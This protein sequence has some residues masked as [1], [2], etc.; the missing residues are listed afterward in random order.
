VP[1]TKRV[2]AVALAAFAF[3]A[4]WFAPRL[5]R[6]TILPACELREQISLGPAPAPTQAPRLH[7]GPT[8][9]DDTAD[10]SSIVDETPAPPC[11]EITDVPGL[12]PM[13]DARGA[14]VIAP[15]R[16]RGV[17]GGKIEASPQC[18]QLDVAVSVADEART[19]AHAFVAGPGIVAVLHHTVPTLGPA[20][21]PA[22]VLAYPP[23]GGGP[24]SGVRRGIEHPPR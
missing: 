5:A 4:T 12:A 9:D 21:H 7:L 20:P 16:I 22:L 14:T 23:P 24:L 11:D 10:P 6:A 17:D 1:S 18:F 15:P 2:L 3:C 13:S 19:S 8:V